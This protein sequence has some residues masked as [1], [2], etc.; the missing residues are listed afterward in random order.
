MKRLIQIFVFSLL[1]AFSTAPS[2]NAGVG[3]F[4]IEGYHVDIKVTAQNTYRIQETI[5]VNFPGQ[6]HGIYRDIPLVNAVQRKDGSSD[7][8]VARIENIRCEDKY[9]TSR[10]GDSYRIQIGDKD[11]RITGDKEYRISYDYVMGNDVLKEQDEFYFNVIGMNWETI[12]KNVTFS[13]EMPKE[14]DVGQLGMSWGKYG[15]DQY[16]GG[17][18]TL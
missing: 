17:L 13:I 8:I 6:R 5:Q 3:D 1:I 7:R 18:Y 2:V 10:E 14:F 15:S 11:V 4:T 12:I 16:D 9:S